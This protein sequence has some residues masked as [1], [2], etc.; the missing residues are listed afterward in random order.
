MNPWIVGTILFLLFRRKPAPP[1]PGYDGGGVADHAAIPE[2]GS[3][4]AGGSGGLTGIGLGA[5]DIQSAGTSQPPGL[6]APTRLAT[7]ASSVPPLIPPPQAPG[8]AYAPATN[9]AAP[10]QT[11]GPT[12]QPNPFQPIAQ[13]TPTYCTNPNPPP[14]GSYVLLPPG[15][16]GARTALVAKMY[17]RPPFLTHAGGYDL[18]ST[19]GGG[20]PADSVAIS[21]APYPSADWDRICHASMRSAVS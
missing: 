5:G 17:L 1:G 2:T 16:P 14:E 9:P 20:D 8:R 3:G 18:L 19:I 13:V 10:V 11:V 7:Q 6:P 12:V 15:T 21:W 4:F